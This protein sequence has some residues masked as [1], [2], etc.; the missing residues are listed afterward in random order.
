MDANTLETILRNH[1]LYIESN[2][3]LG[4]KADLRGANLCGIYLKDVSLY[5][6]DLREANLCGADLRNTDLRKANL[7]RANLVEADFRG[8]NLRESNLGEVNLYGA[9]LQEANLYAADLYKADLSRA[10][11][12][13]ANLRKAN[14]YSA[15]FYAADLS[16]ANLREANLREAILSEANLD[17]TIGIPPIR[18]PEK[19]S[20]TGFKKG[21]I[22]NPKNR[23]GRYV[24]IKLRI[25]ETALRSSATSN[26]CRCSKATVLNITDI[27]DA[28][29]E[30]TKACSLH[31]P[32]FVYV[33][34]QTVE[35]PDFDTNRWE[36]YST[37]I[38]FFMAKQE[39][40][41]YNF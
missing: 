21:I 7:C 2:G 15:D 18:C 34:G 12:Q 9:D 31:D 6:A 37:G 29:K 14:L 27:E 22:R 4:A 23:V 41:E 19:G 1:A 11:L 35:V 24:I 30:Y 3:K 8:A 26:Y 33:V 36:D 5:E 28:T 32:D 10:D 16:R 20:F 25:E 39:A 38:H 13:E 40:I 17:N